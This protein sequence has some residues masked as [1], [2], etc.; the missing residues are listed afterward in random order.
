[1]IIILSCSKTYFCL[2]K[3]ACPCSYQTPFHLF[4]YCCVQSFNIIIKKR[5]SPWASHHLL[6]LLV[7]P[8]YMQSNQAGSSS[9]ICWLC[10]RAASLRGEKAWRIRW[11]RKAQSSERNRSPKTKWRLSVSLWSLIHWLRQHEIKLSNPCRLY[12]TVRHERDKHC[13]GGRMPACGKNS[14]LWGLLLKGQSK[15]VFFLSCYVAFGCCCAKRQHIYRFWHNTLDFNLLLSNFLPP[16]AHSLSRSSYNSAWAGFLGTL[17]FAEWH[18][19]S[20]L[21]VFS[22]AVRAHQLEHTPG[23]ISQ[24]QSQ[25]AVMNPSLLFFNSGHCLVYCFCISRKC[26]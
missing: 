18:S 24:S 22:A 25:K 20:A 4:V 13:L 17:T 26:D 11:S 21:L 10:A 9:R 23:W 15:P 5:F 19:L 1:M 12:T 2:I 16:G 14:G 3:V 8:P 6:R 7:W